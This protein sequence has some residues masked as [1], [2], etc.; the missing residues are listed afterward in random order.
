MANIKSQIK[1][2]V[3][4]EKRHQANVAFKSS[5]KTACKAVEAAVKANDKEKAVSA[6]SFAYKK[7]DKGQAK[8]I[9]HKNFVARHKA[10]LAN[11][12]NSL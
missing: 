6:L 1:R 5:Y 11:L 4:N 10:T 3:I 7:L 8:G 9:F 2:I 12:V